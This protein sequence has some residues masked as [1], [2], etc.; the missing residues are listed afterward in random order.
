MK[1]K[2]ED[3]DF[4]GIK[5]IVGLLILISGFKEVCISLLNGKTESF[6]ISSYSTPTPP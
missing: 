2:G 3:F 4:N 5:P 6:G 1:Q